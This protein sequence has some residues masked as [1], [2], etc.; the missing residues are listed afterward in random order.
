[1]L[2]GY[3]KEATHSRANCRK[4]PFLGSSFQS[5]KE[6]KGIGAKGRFLRW[7]PQG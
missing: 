7:G 4:P 6:G 5:F 1:M 3:K 2:Q